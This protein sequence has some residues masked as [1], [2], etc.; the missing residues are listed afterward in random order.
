MPATSYLC[1]GGSQGRQAG[2]TRCPGTGGSLPPSPGLALAETGAG[3]QGCA[4]TVGWQKARSSSLLAQ[5]E[6]LL[7]GKIGK[8]LLWYVVRCQCT[9]GNM[10]VL[11]QMHILLFMVL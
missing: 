10:H 1:L 9:T 5:E 11:P 3:S 6:V 4:G 2:G 7:Q 8:I